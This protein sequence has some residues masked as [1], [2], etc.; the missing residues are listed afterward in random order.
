MLCPITEVQGQPSYIAK[1]SCKMFLF[2]SL[3]RC[4]KLPR[5]YFME[6]MLRGIIQYLIDN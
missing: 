6:H 3:S 2:Y 4:E 1:G 5:I